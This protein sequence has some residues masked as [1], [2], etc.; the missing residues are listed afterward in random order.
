LRRE[1]KLKRALWFR[2]SQVPSVDQEG[3][4]ETDIP[5]PEHKT[6][7]VNGVAGPLSLA[8]TMW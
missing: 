1:G 3:T 6:T 8:L 2:E 7:A 5:I 4:S